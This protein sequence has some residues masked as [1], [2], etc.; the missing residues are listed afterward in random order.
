MREKEGNRH[1]RDENNFRKII[2]C[3]FSTTTNRPFRNSTVWKSSICLK[4]PRNV[5]GSDSEIREF[6]R[7]VKCF[8]IKQRKQK[9]F[10]SSWISSSLL[11]WTF[12]DIPS[13]PQPTTSQNFCPFPSWLLTLL[14]RGVHACAIDDIIILFHWL[15]QKD[16]SE[17]WAWLLAPFLSHNRFLDISSQDW[18]VPPSLFHLNCLWLLKNGSFFDSICTSSGFTLYWPPHASNAK[19]PLLM[20]PSYPTESSLSSASF[21]TSHG[22]DPSSWMVFPLLRISFPTHL[23]CNPCTFNPF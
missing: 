19:L 22:E 3:E 8:F 18:T 11:L 14:W 20:H 23:Y 7:W 13:N 17:L 6:W 12:I 16:H 1:V 9:S 21:F 2:F 15:K 5:W 10:I 4:D